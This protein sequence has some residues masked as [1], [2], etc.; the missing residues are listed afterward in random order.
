[1]FRHDLGH[2]AEADPKY[3]GRVVAYRLSPEEYARVVFL[4]DFH[5]D[6]LGN[7]A[8]SHQDSFFAR[9][10]EQVFDRVKGETLRPG[11]VEPTSVS[12]ESG[13]VKQP[14]CPK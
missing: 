8:E 4:S 6:S 2:D 12:Y 13:D 7:I 9:F 3:P 11:L 1:M 14:E 10:L 5:F